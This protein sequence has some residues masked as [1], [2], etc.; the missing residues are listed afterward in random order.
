VTL[1]RLDAPLGSVACNTVNST[2]ADANTLAGACHQRSIRV[3]YFASAGLRLQPVDQ[4]ELES[5]LPGR[6][7]RG[8]RATLTAV[9][10]Q[11]EGR[12]GRMSKGPEFTT[13]DWHTAVDDETSCDDVTCK[14][15]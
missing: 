3:L 13:Q 9:T 7:R 8:S 2:L 6:C 5:G 12:G 15:S 4:P 10:L 11:V 1:S 14:A